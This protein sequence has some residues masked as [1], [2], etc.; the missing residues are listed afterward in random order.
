MH[1]LQHTV[2]SAVSMRRPC[3]LTLNADRGGLHNRAEKVICAHS[4]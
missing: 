4:K 1:K 2:K 3:G